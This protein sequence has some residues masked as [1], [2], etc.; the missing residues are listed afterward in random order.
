M[1]GVIS[2]VLKEEQATFSSEVPWK[3]A[4][5]TAGFRDKADRLDRVLFRMGLL[6]SLRSKSVGGAAIGVAITASHNPVEDNGVKIVDPMGEMLLQQWEGHATRL[7]NASVSELGGV[8]ADVVASCGC[9][10]TAPSHLVIARDTRPSGE[11]LAQHLAKAAK[12]LHSKVTD[13]GI[14]T[15]PQL[16]YVV[17]CTNKQGRCGEPTE[18]GYYKKL[19]SAFNQ[20]LPNPLP[21]SLRTSVKLDGANGV[22]ADKMR[23]LMECF[24]AASSE[25]ALAVDVWDNGSV[26]VLNY[27]CGADYVKVTQAPPEGMSYSEGEKCVSFDGDADRIV[28]FYK[29]ADGHFRLLDGDKIAA[30]AAGFISER[31]RLMQ[32]DLTIGVVQTAYSNGSATVYLKETLNIPIACT[33]T[34]V[35]HLHHKAQDFDIGIYFE[36]NGHGTILFSDRASETFK[37]ASEDERLSDATRGAAAQL[38]ALMQLINQAVGDSIADLLMVEAILLLRGWG[39]AE[40]DRLYKELPSRQLKVK[41][42]DRMLVQTTD[43]ERTCVAPSG[44]QDE[45]DRLVHE[46]PQGRA[47]VRPSGTEDVV[48]VYAEAASQESADYLAVQVGAKVHKMADGI[49]ELPS[50]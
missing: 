44:L 21:S 1:E 2:S 43:F 20:L 7:A 47:F 50:I 11:R 39:C 49:G 18:E 19:V 22:G 38:L 36:A 37:M 41:V 27:K 48:R 40:W 24:A 42:R 25:K 33:L 29:N 8:L 13:C 3:F 35:K 28:Y 4:Y 26:G 45:I 30:L 5:G 14:L 10:I 46:V 23:R 6:A 34:G 32:T 17:R 15:T 16:H 31:L 9:D 12:L